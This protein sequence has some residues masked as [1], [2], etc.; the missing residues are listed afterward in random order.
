MQFSKEI[1]QAT[2][3]SLT[4][5]S[6][7][8][9]SGIGIGLVSVA[10][11]PPFGAAAG[12]FAGK[13]VYDKS[14][15]NNVK[16][17]LEQGKLGEVLQRWNQD[18]WR[19]KGVVARLVVKQNRRQGHISRRSDNKKK[20]NNKDKKGPKEAAGR[21]ELVLESRDVATAR[22]GADRPSVI[23]QNSLGVEAN[24][25]DVGPIDIDELVADDPSIAIELPIMSN[26]DDKF[27]NAARPELPPRP[28]KA[29]APSPDLVSEKMGQADAA[30]SS[31]ITDHP[32]LILDSS[33][34]TEVD[35]TDAS[36][37]PDSDENLEAV[38]AQRIPSTQEQVVKNTRSSP[39][40]EAERNYRDHLIIPMDTSLAPA[41]LFAR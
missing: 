26:A 3:L 18:S 29:L 28:F 2:K 32:A 19:E 36:E 16:Q 11:V 34:A 33:S 17:G 38:V 37:F 10:A 6:L 21:F 7:A 27:D 13:A 1:V 41:P 12:V 22:I 4:Q 25:R 39:I 20:D 5:Q 35:E 30:R 8:W 40:A 15:L 23:L 24:H 31:W 9:S 14:M